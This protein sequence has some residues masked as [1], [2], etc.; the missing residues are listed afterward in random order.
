M[1]VTVLVSAQVPRIVNAS[2]VVH[3]PTC[4]GD[5]VI[6]RNCEN[7]LVLVHHVDPRNRH[8]HHFALQRSDTNALSEMVVTLGSEVEDLD[9]TYHLNDMCVLGDSC[10]FC[11]YKKTAYGESELDYEDNITRVEAVCSGFVGWFRISGIRQESAD[12]SITDIGFTQKLTRLAVRRQMEQG[13]PKVLLSAIGCRDTSEDASCVAEIWLSDDG[14]WQYC[15]NSPALPTNENFSDIIFNDGKCTIA[16]TR[17]MADDTSQWVIV[18]HTAES[19]SFYFDYV[20]TGRTEYPIWYNYDGIS[21]KDWEHHLGANVRMC[22][23]EDNSFCMAYPCFSSNDNRNMLMVM[24][25]SSDYVISSAFLVETRHNC[26]ILEMT[27]VRNTDNIGVLIY[28][29]TFYN[30][31]IIS[32]PVNRPGVADVISLSD[33]RIQSVCDY[34]GESVMGSGFSTI[35]NRVTSIY[36]RTVGDEQAE[37]LGVVPR[38]KTDMRAIKQENQQCNWQLV[39]LPTAIIWDEIAGYSSN[40]EQSTECAQPSQVIIIRH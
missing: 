4:Y 19:G 33:V 11:G 32:C 35:N 5:G 17:N 6:A 39:V 23:L 18:G 38:E 27:G 13:Q 16:A 21:I 24:A 3:M 36:K 30:G 31:A 37:C 9:V 28:D 1:M 34:I 12:V 29:N 8:Q 14:S 26:S 40:V 2:A 25:I 10:Y 7:G 15:V 20:Y 22:N